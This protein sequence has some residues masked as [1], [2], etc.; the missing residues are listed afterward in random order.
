MMQNGQSN[1]APPSREA[2]V[3]YLFDMIAQ[4][5]ELARQAGQA[6]VAIHLDALLAAERQAGAHRY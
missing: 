3:D 4:L 1:I 5:A 6:R 2:T